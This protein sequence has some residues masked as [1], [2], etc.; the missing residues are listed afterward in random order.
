MKDDEKPMLCPECGEALTKVCAQGRT[1]WLFED[2]RYHAQAPYHLSIRC[3]R[4]G[5]RVDHLFNIIFN[6]VED[7]SFSM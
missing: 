7:Q 1:T 6:I 4:C 3:P 5:A 2:G